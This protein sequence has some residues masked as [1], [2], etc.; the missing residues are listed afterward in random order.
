MERDEKKS[1]SISLEEE[2]EYGLGLGR[3]LGGLAR[4]EPDALEKLEYLAGVTKR[5]KVEIIS[6]AI[7]LYYENMILSKAWERIK[8]LSAEDLIA[9][10]QL[11]RGLMGIT[12]DTAIGITKEF[13]SGT[14]GAF[15]KMLEGA[16]IEAYAMASESS[17]KALE[18]RRWQQI[19]KMY[20]KFEPILDFVVDMLSENMTRVMFPST[21][22]KPKIKAKITVVEEEEEGEEV[23]VK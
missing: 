6:R 20:E 12:T 18:E 17:K 2:K 22:K 8:H 1:G 3:Y 9:S 4:A 10:W 7:D 5:K 19:S 11:F 23:V 16:R 13:V 21:A 15:Y 14:L